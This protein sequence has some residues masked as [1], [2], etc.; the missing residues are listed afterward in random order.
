MATL[1][2]ML[3]VDFCNV[4]EWNLKAIEELYRSY[5][6][7][8]TKQGKKRRWET[9]CKTK[10]SNRRYYFSFDSIPADES[11]ILSKRDRSPSHPEY[12]EL[13]RMLEKS[14]E[15]Y[16]LFLDH[17]VD[18]SPDLEYINK[19]ASGMKIRF[20]KNPAS[21]F[22]PRYYF[23]SD[24]LEDIESYVDRDLMD[25]SLTIAGQRSGLSGNVRIRDPNVSILGRIRKC[26]FCEHYFIYPD[27]PTRIYCSDDC[28]YA[29]NNASSGNSV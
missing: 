23:E 4:K 21:P 11:V 1:A 22:L 29:Y 15:K 27:P 12:G 9:F 3:L 6:I 5:A 26:P 18:G 10:H 8:H 14:Q 2:G 7:V 16:R 19:L 17:C 20:A 25:A 13:W 28:R 24:R